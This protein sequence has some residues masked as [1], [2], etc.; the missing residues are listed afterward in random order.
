MNTAA[1]ASGSREGWWGA[2]DYVES[3]LDELITW[4]ELGYNMCSQTDDYDHYESLPDWAQRTL[5]AHSRDPR[6]YI[7][8]LE[9]FERAQTHDALWNAAQ[10]QLRQ[11]GHR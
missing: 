11:R 8:D 2:S 6:P 1:K 3:F 7:Y 5:R 4:R 10:R 9:Q